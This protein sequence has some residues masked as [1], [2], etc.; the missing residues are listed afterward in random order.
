MEQRLICFDLDGLY[1]TGESFQRFK[2][3]L[4]PDVAKEKRDQVLALSD[5]MKKFKAGEIS[6]E[7]YR[8][9]VKQEL[10]LSCSNEEIY[11]TLRDSYEANP[12]VQQLAKTLKENG[13]KIGICSNNFPTRIRELDNKF[14]FIDKFDVCVFSYEVGVLKP[15]PG[16]FQILID[17]SGISPENIIYSDDK[18]DKL[19]WAKSLGIQTFVFHSFEEFV[20]DLKKCGVKI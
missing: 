17:R 2:E 6:E 10:W 11:T 3:A 20:D 18:E 13:Y 15:E 8:S 19:H 12:N 5:E 9:R 1:F 16:I 7:T 4:A 14:H